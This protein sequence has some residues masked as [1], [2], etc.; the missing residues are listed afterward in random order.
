MRKAAVQNSDFM[1]KVIRGCRS[2][3]LNRE[4]YS[5]HL[6]LFKKAGFKLIYENKVKS[7][8]QIS[9]VH[10][11][12]RFQSMSEDDFNYKRRIHSGSQEKMNAPACRY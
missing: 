2:Y 6:N 10:L 5:T 9:I 4:P 8:S 1:W 7:E 12:P 11:A 3:L